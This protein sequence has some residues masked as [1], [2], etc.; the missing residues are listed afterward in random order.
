MKIVAGENRR[1]VVGKD[2][3]VGI[4]VHKESWQATRTEK[5]SSR[6]ACRDSNS[7]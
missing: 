2:V 3:Y 7:P 5:R 1:P 6:A 4:D